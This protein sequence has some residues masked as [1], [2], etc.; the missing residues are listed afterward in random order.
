MRLLLKLSGEVLGGRAGL[1]LDP[2]A[3]SHFADTSAAKPPRASI[4][5]KP[6]KSE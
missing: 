5:Q 6:T 3:L 2:E 4:A 1:G